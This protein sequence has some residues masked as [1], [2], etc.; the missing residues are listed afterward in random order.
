MTVVATIFLGIWYLGSLI[1]ILFATNRLA[2]TAARK[3]PPALSLKLGKMLLRLAVFYTH[4][5]E[6]NLF[7]TMF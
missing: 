5:R 7:P 4:L 3:K 6:D 2:P 1:Q